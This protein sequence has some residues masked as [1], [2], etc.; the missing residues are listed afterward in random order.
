V[1]DSVGIPSPADFRGRS[2]L[3]KSRRAKPQERSLI[4]ECVYDCTN[5]FYAADRV[6]H[7]LLAVRLNEF[8]LV[9]DFAAGTDR[10]FNLDRDPEERSPLPVG[11]GEEI[12]RKLLKDAKQ[13]LVESRQSRD[14]DRQIASKVRDYRLELARS[15]ADTARN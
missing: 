14:F 2:Y 6:G 1:V 7:R 3:T 10:L 9:V 15:A 5:P 13:H 11:E 4:S 12:R 8:K